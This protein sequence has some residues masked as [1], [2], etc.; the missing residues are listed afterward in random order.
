MFYAEYV[1]FGVK[2]DSVCGFLFKHT[3]FAMYANLEGTSFVVCGFLFK[4]TLFALLA[5]MT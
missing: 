1:S 4:H 2:Y 3:V 5:W